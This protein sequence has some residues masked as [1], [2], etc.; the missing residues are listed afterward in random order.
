MDL[1][2]PLYLVYNKIMKRRDICNDLKNFAICYNQLLSAIKEYEKAKE[3]YRKYSKTE[4]QI[5]HTEHEISLTR[6]H[7]REIR[8]IKENQCRHAKEKLKYHSRLFTKSQNKLFKE[9]CTKK[10]NVYGK[11]LQRLLRRITKIF[12]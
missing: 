4:N 1:I 11:I 8:K 5:N 7:V 6:M 3:E 9:T 2:F 12:K 10:E